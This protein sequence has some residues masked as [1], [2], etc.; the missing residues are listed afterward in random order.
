LLELI[1]KL[2]KEREI[3]NLMLVSVYNSHL[4]WARL[5]FEVLSNELIAGKLNSYGETARY[6]VRRLR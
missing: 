4:H 5:G 1:A 6:M 3:P 2:A